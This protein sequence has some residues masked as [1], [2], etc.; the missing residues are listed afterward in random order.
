M[1][2]SSSE[3]SFQFGTPLNNQR[4]SVKSAEVILIITHVLVTNQLL[5]DQLVAHTLRA[6]SLRRRVNMD[7]GDEA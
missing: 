5:T 4:G 2:C 6:P 3:K 7:P 1:R